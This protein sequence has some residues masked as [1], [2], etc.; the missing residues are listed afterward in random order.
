VDRAHGLWIA[1]LALW[2]LTQ[3]VYGAVAPWALAAT[4]GALV[5]LNVAAAALLPGAVPLSRVSKTFLAAGAAIFLIQFLPLG[6]L[7]PM[8]SSMRQSHG[9]TGLW[10]GT[11]DTFLTLRCF[12]QVL[13]YVL[14]VLLILKLR[15]DGVS[16]ARMVK[17][18]CVVLVFQ[19]T[20]VLAQKFF[21]LREIPFFGPRT[22]TSSASGTFVN[23]N[24]LAGVLAMGIVAAAALTYSR[25]AGRRRDLGVAWA[26]VTALFVAGLALS[27]SRGGA[28]GAA[29]G[30]IALP[31]LYRGRASPAGAIAVFVAG[32]VGMLLADPAVVLNRFGEIDPQQIQANERWKIWTTTAAA[33]AHQPL[34]GFGVGTHP[35]AYHPYQPPM[36]VGQVHH[37]HN[38][39]V[40]FFFEGGILWAGLLVAGF[41]LWAV[42]TWKG[43]QR[44]QG[45]DRLLPT[46]AIAAACAEA[47]HSFVD[48]DLRTTSA[49]MLFA[50][51]IGLGGS[52]QRAGAA[53]C[54]RTVPAVAGLTGLALL[55]LLLVPLDSDKWVEEATA[56]G[57]ARAAGLCTRALSLSPFNFRAAWVL[58]REAPDEGLADRRFAVAA[59]LWP[60]HPGLQEDVALWFWSRL[61][62]TGDRSCLDR[63][64]VCA[65][66][67]FLQRPWDVERVMKRIWRKDR[68]LQDYSS[69]LPETPAA[70]GG[71]A[72]LL[73]GK[74]RWRDALD[75]FSKGCPEHPA[76]AAVFD[77]FADRLQAEGQWGMEASV[78]ARRVSFRSDPT[79]HG[80]A[81]RAWLRLE[82]F[83]R[84][85]E[86]AQL[87][88]R[89]DPSNVEWV[90]L[91]G[92]IH[93]ASRSLE[94]ALEAYV[95]A[96]R[97]A[98][99]DVRHILRRA[100][101][102]SEMQLHS[103][104]ADDYRQ[105]LRAR[106]GDR[107]ASLG[108]SRALASSNDRV[109][110]RRIVEEFLERH[111]GDAEAMQFR[112]ELAR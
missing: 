57:A 110:A 82:A 22:D 28:L 40:N 20:Y 53:P 32:A 85:L 87:A 5:V 73:V 15:S 99:L 97:M 14:T 60:A 21:G 104:A 100:S 107:E 16:T 72:S 48:F 109:G 50:V 43:S 77:G 63:S 13:V 112:A 68:P 70:A 55:L 23:R 34:F 61:E 75:V 29:V 98:P 19:S 69:L 1:F 91:L 93:R 46:A 66:R 49:G 27:K 38:E 106:P 101:L 30:L 12:V 8:T 18:I 47:V 51:M 67:L 37:A 76:N 31:F 3:A 89:T 90:V 56:N 45:P 39:Y 83:E 26:L 79:A 108:L 74:G 78:R 41:A 17:G 111:P 11:A 59:D 81:A 96:V 52:I 35:H 58:A 65:R 95:E 86:Q 42:R 10:P 71:F 102:Y 54:R 84:A 4:A 62:E 103:S 44:L 9:I 6:F 33:A 88:R 36:L 25:F 64:A 94:R 92:D 24:T 7:F 2:A 105:A 80:A